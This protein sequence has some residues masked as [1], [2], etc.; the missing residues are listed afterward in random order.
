MSWFLSNI[1][2]YNKSN[3][4]KRSFATF[5]A[6]RSQWKKP[7]RIAVTGAN[8]NI[9]YATAF[10]IAN[11]A[12]LGPD[13]PVILHLIDLPNFQSGLQGVNME[14]NDCALPL[15]QG[16]VCTD[17]ASVGF[18]DVDYALLFGAKPRGPGMERQDLLKD[19][20]KIF[21]DTGKAINDNAKRDVKVVTIGNPANTNCMIAQHYAPDLPAENFSAMTRLDHDRGLSQLASKLQV[22]LDQIDRFAVWGNHSPT[23]FPDTSYMTIDGKPAQSMLDKDW[24]VNDF[25]PTVQQR[26]AAIIKAR[27]LSSAASAGNAAM[28]HLRD[29]VLGSQ[30]KWVSMSVKSRGEYGVKEGL[31]FSYPVTTENGQWKIVEGLEIS[32]ESRA[33]IENTEKELEQERDMVSDLLK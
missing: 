22:Q 32:Q 27:K 26:G 5:A 6:P 18:K 1:D 13:Q 31:I 7:V 25:I 4:I 16:V 21:I 30:G 33:M 14:L 3:L 10:R 2:P 9:G 24:L 8:G 11:G 29:W 20:G 17:N 28:Q 23:M 19:N 15:L 12:M